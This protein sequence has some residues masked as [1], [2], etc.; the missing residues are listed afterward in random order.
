MRITVAAPFIIL[1]H[2]SKQQNTDKKSNSIADSSFKTAEYL[3][4]NTKTEN[5]IELK[6]QT[7]KHQT[8]KHQTPKHQTPIS[9]QLSSSRSSKQFLR[10]KRSNKGFFEEAQAP[11]LERECVEEDCSKEESLEANEDGGA[12]YR[13]AT[14]LCANKPCNK[15]GTKLCKNLWL[16]YECLCK[17]G[18]GG[19]DCNDINECEAH[20]SGN[21]FSNGPCDATAMCV[22]TGWF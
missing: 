15:E 22:N 6:H 9:H 7:P 14:N 4:L 17:S 11:N 2:T 12:F 1:I 10:Q 21:S 16:H 18:F 5:P 13:A 19:K 3:K 20:E 8:L